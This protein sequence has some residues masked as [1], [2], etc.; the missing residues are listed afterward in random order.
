MALL[1]SFLTAQYI[2]NSNDKQN[3]I[4]Y[5]SLHFIN[6]CI[7]R[8]E[9]IYAYEE[10]CLESLLFVPWTW[11][12]LKTFAARFEN[13]VGVESLRETM[14]DRINGL[15]LKVPHI[16][17][18]FRARSFG[19]ILKRIAK[20]FHVTRWIKFRRSFARNFSYG[21]RSLNLYESN[22]EKKRT[23]EEELSRKDSKRF[24]GVRVRVRVRVCSYLWIDERINLFLTTARPLIYM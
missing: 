10:C 24:G 14:V 1:F 11:T 7:N 16:S 4:Q 21:I 15:R 6:S 5:L 23:C 13:L 19:W 9:P 12:R 20:C 17:L 2:Y 18:C 3:K 8:Y 22:M